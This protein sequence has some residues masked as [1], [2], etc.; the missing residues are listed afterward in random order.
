MQVTVISRNDPGRGLTD[1]IPDEVPGLV[2]VHRV[3]AGDVCDPMLGN[4]FAPPWPKVLLRWQAKAAHFF[5]WQVPLGFGYVWRGYAGFKL[6]GVDS[7]EYKN[8]LPSW[9]VYNGSQALCFS[10]RPFQVRKV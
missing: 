4:W 2:W 6:Y 5:A 8:W 10:L 7:P 1:P 9:D 3:Y